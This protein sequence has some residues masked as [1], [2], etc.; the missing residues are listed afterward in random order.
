MPKA[1]KRIDIGG[2]TVT[3]YLIQLLKKTGV[4]IESANTY[5]IVRDMKE[6]LCYVSQDLRAE[7]TSVEKH[8]ENTSQYTLPDGQK[9]S[10]GCERSQ[11]PEVLFQPH[12]MGKDICGI[13]ELLFQSINCCDIDLRRDL[14]NNT[15]ITGWPTLFPGLHERLMTE[16]RILAPTT[17]VKAV[18]LPPSDRLFAVWIGGSLLASLS[19]FQ[20]LWIT[21]KDYE[22]SGAQ[23]IH[24][25]CF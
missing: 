5:E 19:S 8:L 15:I 7:T 1:I 9:V 6:N 12:L 13:H 3:E 18:T 2:R 16:L 25:N 10:I 24:K 17:R 22:E 11:A 20:N 14:Y 23:I 4:I 21:K